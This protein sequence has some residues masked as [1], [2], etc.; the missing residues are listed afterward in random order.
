MGNFFSFLSIHGPAR[1]GDAHYVQEFPL[2][3][4]AIGD[5]RSAQLLI[6]CCCAPPTVA[7]KRR[8]RRQRR[9]RRK[10]GVPF[11][12][13]PIDGDGNEKIKLHIRGGASIAASA[14]AAIGSPRSAGLRSAVYGPRP[15]LSRS[16]P[17][18]L[19]TSRPR[20]NSHLPFSDGQQGGKWA[21]GAWTR[22]WVV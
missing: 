14:D 7:Q 11:S 6:F 20:G 19:S 22:G 18:L 15:G 17:V 13:E 2:S 16:G 5:R 8:R 10:R 1:S 9:W 3:V 4:S 12:L 21:N